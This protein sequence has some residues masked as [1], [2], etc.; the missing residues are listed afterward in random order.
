MLR[1]TAH[2]FRVA[3]PLAEPT[4][5]AAM[6]ILYILALASLLLMSFAERTNVHAQRA[7]RFATYNFYFDGSRW[8]RGWFQCDQVH[9]SVIVLDPP[10]SR[11]HTL[12]SFQKNQPSVLN[13]VQ[14]VQ[15]GE[16]ESAMGGKTSWTFTAPDSGPTYTILEANYNE[17]SD[18]RA[19]YW[20]RRYHIGRGPDAETALN[21]LQECRWF[22]RTRVALITDTAS[23]YVT[24]TSGGQPVLTSYDYRHAAEQPTLTLASGTIQRDRAAHTESFTF[25]Q[26]PSTY[27]L[28][29]SLSEPPT[30][31]FSLRQHKAVIRQDTVRAYTYV[32][33]P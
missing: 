3:H 22:P 12:V 24:E 11:T 19:G 10:T 18:P 13:S 7:R 8:L 29:V 6:P 28:T 30:V 17:V 31:Q 23:L 32:Q 25:T 15:Q 4:T 5:K 33:K 9:E 27:V 16:A 2:V 26:G 1:T 20:T 21:T 14:L